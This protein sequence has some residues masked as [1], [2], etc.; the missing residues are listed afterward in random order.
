MNNETSINSTSRYPGSRPFNDSDM[1]RRLFFGR[2]QEKADLLHKVL[3]NN[4]VVVFAKS[5]IGKTSLLNAGIHQALRDRGYL[6][7]PIRFNIPELDPL[8]CIYYG[9]KEITTAR[10]IDFTDGEKD[11]LWM[12]FKTLIIW[13]END[14]LLKPVL[15]FDQFEE[16][17]ETYTI[18]K[19]NEFI[20]QLADLVS[21][22]IPDTLRDSIQS[23]KSSKYSEKTPAVKIIISIREDLL[24]YLEEMS[25][26]ITDIFNNR[27]KLSPLTWEQAKKAIIEPARIKDEA[28]KTVSFEY[29]PTAEDMIH[30]FLCKRKERDGYKITNE[31]ESYQLQLVCQHIEE[32]VHEKTKKKEKKIVIKPEDIGGEKGIQQILEQFYNDSI[33]R[34]YSAEDKKC[35]RKLCENGLISCMN[36]RLS[37]DEGEI[38]RKFKV[39][40]SLLKTLV[41]YRLLRSEPRLGGYYYELTH[42]TLIKPIRDAQQKR[43]DRKTLRALMIITTLSCVLALIII[44]TN[45]KFGVNTQQATLNKMY[46]EAEELANNSNTDEAIKKYITILKQ[47]P[48]YLMATIKLG[49]LLSDAERDNEAIVVYKNAINN[50]VRDANVYTKLGKLLFKIGYEQEAM[51]NINQAIKIN[52]EDFASYEILG[53]YFRDTRNYKAAIENYK[54][55]LLINKLR[56]DIYEKLAVLYI[57][58]G[59]KN[60]AMDVFNRAIA[61]DKGFV[62]IYQEVKNALIEK[63]ESAELEKFYDIVL[64]VSSKDAAHYYSLGYNYLRL[65]KYDKAIIG[66][67]KALKLKPDYADA[68]FNLGNCQ[69]KKKDYDAA[70]VSFQKSLKYKPNNALTYFTIGYAQ[71]RKGI[72]SEAIKSFQKVLEINPSSTSAKRNLAELYLIT[73]CFDEASKLAHEILK[74][75]QNQ[76]DRILAMKFLDI[77]ALFSS[78]NNTNAVMA[79]KQ[80]IFYYKSLSTD[81][82][83]EWDYSYTKQYITQTKHLNEKIRA[84]LLNVI[85]LLE[86]PKEKGYQLLPKLEKMVQDYLY[87]KKG[88]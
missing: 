64:P 59:E 68:Y 80:L 82:I 34:L 27:F 48:K 5:G 9:V 63:E 66:F 10:Q 22:S 50:G 76:Q 49:D 87:P 85:E 58:N 60:K 11:S 23:G 78:G 37:L 73:E 7:I 1:D 13:S 17:F 47:N 14:T 83:P 45:V 61:V 26:K 69:T 53:D 62:S 36:R 42:D 46:I 55:V 77:S 81:Y 40:K 15:I 54:K 71:Y 8:N 39:S 51:I 4:L 75:N 12:Y 86:S 52:P 72:Y 16:L 24:G 32:K 25:S 43:Q 70:L 35:A 2:E 21:D 29:S 79:L 3:A 33:N 44:I 57:Q 30:G 6:P 31:V 41:D 84:I 19:R 67:Q 65:N 28:I 20:N 38:E 74:E 18:E 88:L 56:K